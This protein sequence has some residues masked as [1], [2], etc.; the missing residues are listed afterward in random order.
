MKQHITVGQLNELSDQRKEKLREWWNPTDTD[1]YF[2]T[3]IHQ[4]GCDYDGVLKFDYVNKK[5][6]GNPDDGWDAVYP[7]LSIGQ[8][9]EF[10]HDNDPETLVPLFN[11][12]AY[13]IDDPNDDLTFDTEIDILDVDKLCDAL[14]EA[15]KEV[16][17]S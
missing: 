13:T 3:D 5:V 7:A 10:L 17:E 1:L 11:K 15:V 4:W 12:L 14:W 16:L 8:M 9:I 6:M 2:D